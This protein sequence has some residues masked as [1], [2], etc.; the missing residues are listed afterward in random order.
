[1]Q[2]VGD[3]WSPRGLELRDLMSRFNVPFGFYDGDSDAGR[4]LLEDRGLVEAKLPVWSSASGPARQ[5]SRTRPTRHSP[6][7]SA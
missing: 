7:R 6:T 3:R 1:M 4:A 2:I 5:R